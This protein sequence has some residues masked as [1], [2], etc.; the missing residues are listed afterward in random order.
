MRK[1][2]IAYEDDDIK[3]TTYV[4]GW[5]DMKKVSIEFKHIGLKIYGLTCRFGFSIEG[6]SLDDIMKELEESQHVYNYIKNN[7]DKFDIIDKKIK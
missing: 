3:V 5:K 6:S 2:K 4:V 1:V 7:K